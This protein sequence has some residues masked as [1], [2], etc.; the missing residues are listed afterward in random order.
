MWSVR[1]REALRTS[2]CFF[3]R[4]TGK[5]ELSLIEIDKKWTFKSRHGDREA[6][7]FQVDGRAACVC[8]NGMI[9]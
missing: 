1:G 4:A 9:P 7:A 2:A 3:I 8:A 5:M 6:F